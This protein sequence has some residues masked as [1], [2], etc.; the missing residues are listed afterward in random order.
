MLQ[1]SSRYLTQ[2][3]LDRLLYFQKRYGCCSSSWLPC[4]HLYCIIFS[5]P[6]NE[7]LLVNLKLR[8]MWLR[9]A[10]P[11]VEWWG[12]TPYQILTKSIWSRNA[13]DAKMIEIN[14]WLTSVSI[15]TG[16]QKIGSTTNNHK[17]WDNYCF[18]YKY[19]MN[20]WVCTKGGTPPGGST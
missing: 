5:H 10:W 14:D 3:Q 17:I 9:N 20:H 12:I 7:I 1:H 16:K 11:D 8:N 6:E 15:L 18:K 13:E 19:R 2:A 4:M